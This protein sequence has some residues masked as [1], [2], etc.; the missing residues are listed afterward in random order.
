MRRSTGADGRWMWSLILRTADHFCRY[1][2]RC[3]V[4]LDL[5]YVDHQV[6]L[7][8]LLYREWFWLHRAMPKIIFLGRF[9]SSLGQDGLPKVF[10]CYKCL[11]GR[12]W[13][14]SIS[15]RSRSLL[16]KTCHRPILRSLIS[17]HMGNLSLLSAKN[18]TVSLYVA[19]SQTC[20]SLHRKSCHLYPT[21][22]WVSHRARIFRPSLW[23]SWS[24]FP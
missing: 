13:L 24:T 20:A 5:W 10:G 19:N 16:L 17:F 18:M 3:I 11:P 6:G 12:R 1:V 21:G 14:L 7:E 15:R 2:V 22:T 4:R 8:K 23:F 9:L